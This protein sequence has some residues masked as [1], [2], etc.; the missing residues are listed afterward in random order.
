MW[1]LSG[2]LTD[3]LGQEAIATVRERLAAVEEGLRRVSTDERRRDAILGEVAH[4]AGQI[5]GHP[6]LTTNAVLQSKIGML[7]L[8]ESEEK[9]DQGVLDEAMTR[10]RGAR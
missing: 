7:H 10:F 1:R 5:K 3:S 4:L 9:A 6:S 8:D 2:A